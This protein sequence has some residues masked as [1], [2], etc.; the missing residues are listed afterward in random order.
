MKKENIIGVRT[1]AVRALAKTLDNGTAAAFLQKLPHKYHEE[2]LLHAA[3]TERIKDFGGCLS[4]AE[5]FLPYID[6]WAVCDCFNPKAFAKNKPAL[7]SHIKRWLKSKKTYTVRFGLKTLMNLYLDGDFD[8]SY[9][10]L[11]ALT[12]TREYYLSMMT[13][14]Y[15]A[16]ALAKQYES[17]LPYI[18]NRRLDA[19][20]HNRAVQKAL[21]SFR[22]PDDRKQYLKTLK[23]K[24]NKN[25]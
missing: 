18:E 4:A 10:E 13:A 3:L 12:D 11:A 2:N 9:L 1:P 25:A 15:F 21:E 14:W 24:E 5:A 22:V 8:P 6:N 17:A 7:L 16:T 19:A 20:T 23:I